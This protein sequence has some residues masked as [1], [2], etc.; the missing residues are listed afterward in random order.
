MERKLA[1]YVNQKGMFKDMDRS[2]FN[3]EFIYHGYNIRLDS[4]DGETLM[5]ISNERGN[6]PP[7]KRI[8]KETN[9]EEYYHLD[10]DGDVIGYCVVDK[11]LVL[12]TDENNIYRIEED[13]NGN[14]V[15]EL[16]FYNK[17]LRFSKKHLIE[18]FGVLETE[19]LIKV[20]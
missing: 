2:K 5:A 12:F 20:Y 10:I 8:N 3:P 17:D 14:L 6:R 1:Q 15:E 11:Y 7:N 18:A 4:V 16:W 13:D 9:K 19:N